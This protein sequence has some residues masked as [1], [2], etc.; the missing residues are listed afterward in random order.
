MYECAE[1]NQAYC[2]D[3]TMLLVIFGLNKKISLD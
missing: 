3:N 2:K 1:N